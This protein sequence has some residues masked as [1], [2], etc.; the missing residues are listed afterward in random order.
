MALTVKVHFADECP[1]YM[2]NVGSQFWLL[3]LSNLHT[4]ILKS[5]SVPVY[6][7]YSYR[8]WK[9]I[10]DNRGRQVKM[11]MPLKKFISLYTRNLIFTNK[12]MP[13][14]DGHS[15]KTGRVF[16]IYH[17]VLYRKERPLLHK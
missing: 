12:E 16:Q 3:L 2:K 13:L 14:R 1:T 4:R 17:T 8:F 11:K 6:I 10:I 7:V 15:L 5:F 9:Q